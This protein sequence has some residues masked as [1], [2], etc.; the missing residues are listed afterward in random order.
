MKGKDTS[1]PLHLQFH[2]KHNKTFP[3]SKTPFRI[4]L[5]PTKQDIDKS[6]LLDSNSKCDT[7]RCIKVYKTYEKHQG[8]ALRRGLA[9][10]KSMTE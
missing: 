2:L 4:F 7:F 9:A 1:F 8:F 6:L 5:F 10:P 3:I